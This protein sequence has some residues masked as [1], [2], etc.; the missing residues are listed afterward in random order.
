MPEAQI[1]A[2]DPVKYADVALDRPRTENMWQDPL[3]L[4]S[5]VFAT[6]AAGT[7]GVTQ[8]AAGGKK[9]PS[10]TQTADMLREIQYVMNRLLRGNMPPR[11]PDPRV[12]KQLGTKQVAGGDAVGPS[13]LTF[14]PDLTYN[15]SSIP[16]E[17]MR[18][19]VLTDRNIAP[20]IGLRATAGSEASYPALS[21]KSQAFMGPSQPNVQD[22]YNE[23]RR[24]A[25]QG[26]WP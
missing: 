14:G 2:Y 16:E 11:E 23:L 24:L 5:A 1:R 26:L 12:I 8:T 9:V 7:P 10:P 20:E 18:A 6:L 15:F 4:L 22:F 13:P 25:R 21:M 17:V 3:A 19:V